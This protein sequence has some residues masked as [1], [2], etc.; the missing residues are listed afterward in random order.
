MYLKMEKVSSWFLTNRSLISSISSSLSADA[1]VAPAAIAAF[2]AA[3]RSLSNPSRYESI[4]PSVSRARVE[5][6]HIRGEKL[7]EWMGGRVDEWT[8]EWG[9]L[10]YAENNSPFRRSVSTIMA[11]SCS[12]S[13]I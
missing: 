4:F 5:A 7:D 2:F 11:S 9:R 12:L 10:G 8:S 1:G 13:L 3:T 6:S